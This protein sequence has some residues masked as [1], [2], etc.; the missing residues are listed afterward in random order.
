M[1]VGVL[2]FR[3]LELRATVLCLFWGAWE[4][5]GF[6]VKVFGFPGFNVSGLG[7]HA[8]LGSKVAGLELVV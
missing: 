4:F 7:F 1:G 5:R 3:I 2:G 8:A 6:R